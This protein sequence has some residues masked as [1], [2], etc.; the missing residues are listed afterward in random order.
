MKTQIFHDIKGHHFIK[1]HFYSKIILAHSFMYRFWWKFVWMLISWRHNFFIKSWPE[2][3]FYVFTLRTSDLITTLTYI[4]MENICPCF[5]SL[6]RSLTL[7]LSLSLYPP[8]SLPKYSYPS[9]L[10]IFSNQSFLIFVVW[11]H[12]SSSGLNIYFDLDLVWR[13]LLI[14]I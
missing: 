7:S 3:H 10:N 14:I 5:L 13:M 6:S 11:E 1:D 8:L 12:P 4:L 2:C 9:F